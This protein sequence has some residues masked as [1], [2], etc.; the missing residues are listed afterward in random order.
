[1]PI[2]FGT[3]AGALLMLTVAGVI[4]AAHISIALI[5]FLAIVGILLAKDF[6]NWRNER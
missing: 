5:I 4:N 6:I 1:M 3:I 2:L